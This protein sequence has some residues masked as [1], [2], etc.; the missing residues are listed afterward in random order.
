MQSGRLERRMAMSVAARLELRGEPTVVEPVII[1]NISTHG[2]CIVA[3]RPCR[4][5]DSIV[6]SDLLGTFRL[7]ARVI[8]CSE[9][10]LDGQCAIGLQFNEAAA[11]PLG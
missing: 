1:K 5:D 4:V 9:S 6:I 3:K 2:A 8:Y 11:V 10:L 7:A